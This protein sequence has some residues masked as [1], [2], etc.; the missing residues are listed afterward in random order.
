M[1]GMNGPGW[2]RSPARQPGAAAP[3]LLPRPGAGAALGFAAAVGVR[4]AGGHSDTAAGDVQGELEGDVPLRSGH[5]LRAHRDRRPC[6][7]H[8]TPAGGQGPV[9]AARPAATVPDARH[10]PAHLTFRRSASRPE[11]PYPP[12]HPPRDARPRGLPEFAD[13][14]SAI[15]ERPAA[16][17]PGAATTRP[18]AAM[19]ARR[20]PI[21]PLCAA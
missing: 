14:D 21:A 9:V 7:T 19:T 15:I 5:Q 16:N 13:L 20:A 2:T 4:R 10:A 18:R 11:P 8:R 3:G 17:S 1:A 6:R 12:H